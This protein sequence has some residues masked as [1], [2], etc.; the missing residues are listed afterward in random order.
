VRDAVIDGEIVHP[1][2]VSPG[3]TICFIGNCLRS[4]PPSQKQAPTA[5]F[6]NIRPA[7]GIEGPASVCPVTTNQ[8]LPA[9]SRWQA[10]SAL[11]RRALPAERRVIQ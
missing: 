6:H 7:A 3:S 2:L 4:R 10:P 5:A 8:E 1:G 11:R 9:I